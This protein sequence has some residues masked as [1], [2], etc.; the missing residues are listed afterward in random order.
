MVATCAGF[1][2]MNSRK[3]STELCFHRIPTA[4]AQNKLLG[5]RWIQNINHADPLPK[6]ENFFICLN[7]FKKDY[8]ERDFKARNI[9]FVYL[10]CIYNC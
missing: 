2:C 6:D 1:G 4:N 10:T 3:N 8:F 9:V 7:H 5:Q